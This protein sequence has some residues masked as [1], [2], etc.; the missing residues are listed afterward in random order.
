MSAQRASIPLEDAWMNLAQE[1]HDTP[2]F[3]TVIEEELIPL[4]PI[5]A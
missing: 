1:T 2:P 5:V 4:A 3:I